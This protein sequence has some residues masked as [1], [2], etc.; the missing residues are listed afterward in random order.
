MIQAAEKLLIIV[1]KNTS[2]FFGIG[3]QN[4][5]ASKLLKKEEEKNVE[6]S[7][8]NQPKNDHS[9]IMMWFT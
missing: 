5:N 9:W 1:P 8:Q 3:I 7:Q 2:A 6:T 4:A